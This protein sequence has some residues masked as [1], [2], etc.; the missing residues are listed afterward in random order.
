MDAAGTL[1]FT[2]TASAAI[3]GGSTLAGAV[4]GTATVAPA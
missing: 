3:S 2:S 4:A 1:R